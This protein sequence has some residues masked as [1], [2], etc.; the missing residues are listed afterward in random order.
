MAWIKMKGI[1][2]KELIIV[3]NYNLVKAEYGTV[4]SYISSGV[5]GGTISAYNGT[6]SYK[7][8]RTG[9]DF[10]TIN[11]NNPKVKKYSKAIIE[12]EWSNSNGGGP[13]TGGA[14]EAEIFI[15]GNL[16]WSYG[17]WVYP[18]DRSTKYN[19][20]EVPIGVIRAVMRWTMWERDSVE[21]TAR[22]RK[23]TLIK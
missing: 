13:H 20:V 2:D 4:H 9:K 21:M 5:I 14:C 6:E 7:T 23:V 17:S 15:D 10:L 16:K 8:D 12:L 11:K 18:T 1:N 3:D 22:I 19:T